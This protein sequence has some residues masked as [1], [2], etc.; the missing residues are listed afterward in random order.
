MFCFQF[1]RDFEHQFGEAGERAAINL[2]NQLSR[3]GPSI[4]AF[5]E[6]GGCL[7]SKGPQLQALLDEIKKPD[8]CEGRLNTIESLV[9]TTLFMSLRIR[10]SPSTL[11]PSTVCASLKS[12]PFIPQEIILHATPVRYATSLSASVPV[13]LIPFV[14]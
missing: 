7:E 3:H 13:H 6:R 4:I 10:F 12:L 11:L 9:Y 8:N 1:R 2:V 5:A 14:P